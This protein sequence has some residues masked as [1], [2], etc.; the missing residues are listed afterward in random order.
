MTGT[1]DIVTLT[2][3][4]VLLVPNAALRFTPPEA[5]TTQKKS[6]GSVVGALMPRLPRQ[7]PKVQSA[8]GNGSPRVW[9]LRDGQPAAVEIKTGA[10]NGKMTEISG[11]SLKAGTQVITE[12]LGGS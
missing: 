4:N 12:T 11:G 8:T 9:V 10:T 3:A 6:G 1:A 5:E 2:H 7:T